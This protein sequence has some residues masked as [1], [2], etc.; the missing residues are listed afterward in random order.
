MLDPTGFPDGLS[1]KF[2][3]GVKDDSKVSGQSKLEV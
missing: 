1:V 2:E 3:R